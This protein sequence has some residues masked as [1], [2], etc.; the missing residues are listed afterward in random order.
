MAMRVL[1]LSLGSEA[2]GAV[3]HAL[4]AEG[5]EIATESG[6]SV[7]QVLTLAPE[8]L[9]TEATPS[10]LSCCG[11]ISQLKSRPDTR[12]LKI[13][14]VIQG[15]ALER[16]RALDLGADDVISFPFD[17]AEFAARI[18]TQ[19]RERQP[20]EDLK[21]MLKYAAQRE[22]LADLAVE[23]LSGGAVT[24]RRFWLIPAI[25]VLSVTAVV[26]AVFM[27]V[28]NHR[29]RKDTLQLKAEIAR[30]NFGLGQQGELFRRA[31]Q[32]RTSLDAQ[33]RSDSATRDSLKAKSDDLRKKMAAAPASDSD[34]LRQQLQE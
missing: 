2:L 10:D 17:A 23:T 9:V 29:S 7:D 6:R 5:Y 19:F 27:A 1:L 21:T 20:E 18:R 24:K 15:G 4:A 8:V 30:L 33:A 22:N 31:D 14:M 25:F 12:P 11:L 32:M 26:A 28:P 3:Q 16:A 13:V 34:L